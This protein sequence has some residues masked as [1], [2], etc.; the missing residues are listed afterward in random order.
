MRKDSIRRHKLNCKN[1]NM[2]LASS[3]NLFSG[4]SLYERTLTLPARLTG[5]NPLPYL[6]SPYTFSPFTLSGEC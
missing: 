6:E 4:R 3:M 1:L 2:G 5:R